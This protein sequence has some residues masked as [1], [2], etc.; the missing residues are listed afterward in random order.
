MYIR[1]L[2]YS[3]AINMHEWMLD[4][5]VTKWLHKE[6]GNLSDEDVKFYIDNSITN[7]EINFAI[8][9]DEDEYV[10]TTSICNIDE[11]NKVA[12][13]SIVVLSRAMGKGYSWQ[14]MIDTLDYAFNNYNIDGIYWRVDKDNSRALRFFLKH[15]FNVLDEDLPKSILKK[16]YMEDGLVWFAVLRGDDYANV[17]LSRKTVAGCQIVD[18]KTIPT[19]N[20]GEL[21]FFESNHLIE[22]DIKRIYYISKVPEG[23]RRGFHAHKTLKQILFCPYGRIQ[24]IL[25]NGSTREEITLSDPSVGII[26]DKPTWREMIWLQKDSVLVVAAS[27]Y[28]DVDDYIRDYKEFLNLVTH[29][30]YHH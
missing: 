20:A 26:I 11:E 4:S 5:C 28:Y 23:T 14:G 16:H 13:F 3:D 29:K 7:T 1:K 21:S 2:R 10:G 30:S 17:A 19:I 25:D 9:T 15:G 24:L 6:Y 8:A 27:D 12:E 22:F 18:I